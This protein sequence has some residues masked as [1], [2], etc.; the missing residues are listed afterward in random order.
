MPAEATVICLVDRR[1][2]HLC[3]RLVA[4]GFEV[5]ES[6]ATDQAVALCVSRDIAAAVIDEAVF[7]NNEGWTVARSLKMVRPSTCVLL[8][9]RS[10]TKP[11]KLPPHVDALVP[12]NRPE[13]VIARLREMLG[14]STPAASAGSI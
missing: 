8:A 3:R 14:G 13:Q 1:K 9:M 4:A 6:Y 7:V 10:H 2:N 5:V 12:M 11:K